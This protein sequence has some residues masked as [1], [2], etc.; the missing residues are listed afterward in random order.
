MQN[1]IRAIKNDI[2]RKVSGISP[3]L[4]KRANSKLPSSRETGLLKVKR[5][6]KSQTRASLGQVQA[7]AEATT[8]PSQSGSSIK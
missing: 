2:S 8:T 7:A 6:D 3:I 1:R 5:D 4:S